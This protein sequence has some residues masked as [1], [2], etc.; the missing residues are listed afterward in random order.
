MYCHFEN[1]LSHSMPHAYVAWLAVAATTALRPPARALPRRVARV[2]ASAADGPSTGGDDAP[3]GL[4]YYQGMVTSEPSADDARGLRRGTSTSN[5]AATP[6]R[7]R[8]SG[9]ARRTELHVVVIFA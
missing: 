4:E 9:R 2:V 8:G 5:A 6:R 7:R 1:Q 3:R